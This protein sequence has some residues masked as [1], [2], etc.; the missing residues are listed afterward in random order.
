MRSDSVKRVEMCMAQNL[1]K[2]I[3]SMLI[4]GI[5]TTLMM[6]FAMIPIASA[7]MSS[8]INILSVISLI[9]TSLVVSALHFVLQY[10][11]FVLVFLLYSGNY[12]VIGHL[13]SG[14]Y[15]FKR[16][17]KIG[18]IFS[19]VYMSVLLGASGVFSFLLQH[20]KI[21]LTFDM[22]LAILGIISLILLA[23]LYMH[24]AFAW[25]LL[26]E[27]PRLTVKQGLMQSLSIVKG[28][29]I[30]FLKFCFSCSSYYIVIFIACLI[31]LQ[32]PL[33]IDTID[34]SSTSYVA[35]SN[36]LN[37]VYIICM[38]VTIMK[39]SL[40]FASWY[41]SYG[42]SPNAID[43]IDQRYAK[44]P[45]YHDDNESKNDKEKTE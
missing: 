13:F 3:I 10:G 45:N 8:T 12:A 34:V 15:D 22:L 19:A 33:F 23:I 1:P 29:K 11:F 28:K 14:F 43:A 39:I 35:F 44:L 7:I 4:M 38:Y 36:I 17:F 42:E 18:I 2:L 31:V 20:E 32:I 5:L 27:N 40:A 24:F 41:V 30:E 21:F 9:V 37:F 26:Y 6:A 16:S 25:F